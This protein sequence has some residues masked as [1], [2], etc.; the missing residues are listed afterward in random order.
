M[1]RETKGFANQAFDSI[2]SHR[3]TDM[4]AHA[5]AQPTMT[6][7]IG[8]HEYDQLVIRR[9]PLAGEHPVEITL[10]AQPLRSRNLE[11]L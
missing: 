9:P 4:L 7:P 11:S 2:A 6:E 10:Q 5:Q 8:F 1:L 3:T